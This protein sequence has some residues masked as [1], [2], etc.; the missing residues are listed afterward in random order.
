M[1]ERTIKLTANMVLAFS[2]R[3]ADAWGFGKEMSAILMAARKSP[4]R[5]QIEI[6]ENALYD[7]DI[8]MTTEDIEKAFHVKEVAPDQYK[9]VIENTK[10]FE[11]GFIREVRLSKETVNIDDL[12]LHDLMFDCFKHYVEALHK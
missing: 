1:K 3:W 8:P 6:L 4:Y 2:L 7:W 9:Y 11:D 5:D 10:V 12:L